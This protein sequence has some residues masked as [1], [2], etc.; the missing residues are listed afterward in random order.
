MVAIEVSG[1][2]QVKT[3]EGTIQTPGQKKETQATGTQ[4]E[5][6]PSTQ[7]EQV[8]DTLQ[9]KKE[10]PNAEYECSPAE[11]GFGPI[12]VLLR[13]LKPGRYHVYAK[14]TPYDYAGKRLGWAD[15]NAQIV[16][17]GHE[18]EQLNWKGDYSFVCKKEGDA[19][20]IF[21]DV[22][23]FDVSVEGHVTVSRVFNDYVDREPGFRDFI[24]TCKDMQGKL[25]PNATVKVDVSQSE[26]YKN[27]LED[28]VSVTDKEGKVSMKLPLGEFT[29]TV[30]CVSVHVIAMS[31]VPCS[32]CMCVELHSKNNA[33]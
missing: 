4:Q 14:C 1:F 17:Y 8:P 9:G 30:V 18:Q 26:A 16:M 25:V 6:V 31:S 19:S 12:S 32:V 10:L 24:I 21:W 13:A 7:Q 15:S 3:P 2:W 28:F 20:N 23:F 11:G 29:A 33:L 27:V 5:Q 22:C